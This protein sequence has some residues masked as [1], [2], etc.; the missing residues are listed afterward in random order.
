MEEV[1]RFLDAAGNPKHRAVPMWL[2]AGK[3]DF[4]LT[5]C[6]HN[7]FTLPHD[8]NPPLLRN[9]AVLLKLPFQ[10]VACT[11]RT[12]AAD[13]KHKLCRRLG[14]IGVPHTRDQKLNPHCRPT[15][16]YRLGSWTQ[17]GRGG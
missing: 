4:P 12:F 2:R 7:V 6:F 10:T 8:P 16:R 15:V 17:S 3:V 5:G 9:R 13:P 14:F 11:L 1:E